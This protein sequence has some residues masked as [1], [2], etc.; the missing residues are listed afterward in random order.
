MANRLT[1]DEL[2]RIKLVREDALQ[3]ISSIGELEY[4]KILI[5]DEVAKVKKNI[6]E[7]KT[8]EASIFSDLKD[9]YGVV[10]I[11]LETG[12]FNQ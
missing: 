5:D 1:E 11:N 6:L 4:Q 2:K 7:I 10:S 9:K 12:E 3:A 8:R